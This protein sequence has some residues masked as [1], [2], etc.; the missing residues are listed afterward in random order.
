MSEIIEFKEVNY[1]MQIKQNNEPLVTIQEDGTVVIHKE[2]AVKEAAKVFYDSFAFEG[3][4][5]RQQIESLKSQL[6]E[7]DRLLQKAVDRLQEEANGAYS[8]GYPGH[9]ESIEEV[10]K[11]IRSTLA[12]EGEERSDLVGGGK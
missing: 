5:L 2:G 4:T 3:K 1:C 6:A 9:A 10:I 7:K 12:E 11:E 8:D